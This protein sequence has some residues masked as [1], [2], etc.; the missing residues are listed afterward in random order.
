MKTDT[1]YVSKEFSF[2]ILQH[3]HGTLHTHR[4]HTDVTEPNAM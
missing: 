4:T 2:S 3:M 1:I